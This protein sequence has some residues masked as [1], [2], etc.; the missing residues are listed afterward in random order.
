MVKAALGYVK[1]LEGLGFYDTVISLKAS[2]IL[3]TIDCYRKVAKLC[4]YPLHLGV[5]ATGTPS[6]GAIKSGIALGSLLLEGIGDTIRVSLTENP[7]QEVAAA[8]AILESLELRSFGPTIVSCPTCGRCEVD[9]VKIVRELESKLS[10]ANHGSLTAPVKLAVMGCIV[11]GPGEAKEADIGVAFGR[12]EGL[13]FKRGI[14]VKKIT[15]SNCVPVLL[16]EME[17]INA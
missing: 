6:S 8:K 4:N 3:D 14:R 5:T 12:K 16:K 11:N 17:T 10:A 9:L 1:I 13:L 7:L 15:I 2:N